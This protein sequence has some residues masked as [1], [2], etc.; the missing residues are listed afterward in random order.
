MKK[1]LLFTFLALFSHVV[2]AQKGISYQ[3][4]IIDP[5]PIEIPGKDI[6]GQPFVNGSVWVKFIINAG[7]VP[8]FQEVHQTSTDAYGLVNLIIGSVASS[9]FNSLIWDA[10]QKTLEVH[11]SF[12]QGAS[13]AKVSDQKLYYNPYSL[14]AETAGKLNGIL[15]ISGGGTGATSAVGARANLGLGNV[16]NTADAEKPVSTAG[17]AALNLK[18]DKVAGERL[19]NA[20]EIIKLANQSGINTGDQD[21]SSFATK[22][23]VQ[24]SISS[25]LLSLGVA[26]SQ[27]TAKG[28]TLDSNVL[29]LSP[30]NEINA[31]IVV[32]TDQTFGGAK[33][34]VD[35][36]FKR[37]MAA[38][39]VVDQSN[40]TSYNGAGGTYQWQSFT[41][42]LTGNLSSV[43]WKMGTPTYPYGTAAN[44][45]LQL[46]EGEG[47]DGILLATVTG[48]TPADGSNVFVSFPL[49]NVNVTAGST[50]TMYLTTPTVTIGWL[51]VNVS[52]SYSRGRGSNDPDWDYI[53][54]TNVKVFTIDPYLTANSTSTITAGSFVKAGGTSSEYLMADGTVSTLQGFVDL[55]NNQSING[56]KSFVSQVSLPSLLFENGNSAWS[57][58]G[59][60]TGISLIQGGCCSR[61]I[62]DDL[63]RVAIGANYSPAYQLD[64]EGN[65]RFTQDITVNDVIIGK[66]GGS[67]PENLAIGSTA[68]FFNSSGRKNVGIGNAAL[69]FNTSGA[70]NIAVGHYALLNNTTGSFNTAIG[71]ESMSLNNSGS[72][73]TAYGVNSLFANTSGDTNTAIG[74]NS[75][76]NNSTGYKNTAIG[77][78]SLTSNGTGD[79]LT[80][81]GYGADVSV[82]GLSNAIAIGFDAKV[83]TSNSIQLGNAEITTVNT[84]GALTANASV[85][86]DITESFTIDPSNAELYKGKII[87]CNPSNAI[88]ITFSAS[89]PTGFNCMVLQK[90]ADANKVT[91][92]GGTGVTIKNRNNFTATA[93]NYALLT[94]VHIGSNI[95]VTAGDMQ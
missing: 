9:S 90:S 60:G 17:L 51:D 74:G 12:N 79:K 15:G 3:A 57:F 91:I 10:N 36:A 92:V 33:T 20:S 81:I 7:S 55:T 43:E 94:V 39:A 46:Y 86:S 16:D 58:G 64:V 48:L 40:T 75:L 14:Y 50:Y 5:N 49:T 24:S 76:E 88:T 26:N 95:L 77:Y 31:G 44:V 6:T 4:V 68:L 66:G 63:G 28:A 2:N 38:N 61:L 73:N 65:A 45:T 82:D 93:G 85:S 71:K 25:N 19:I 35:G 52:N 29:K 80:S 72:S 53:F 22:E 1:I 67:Q 37:Q 23:L 42:G 89:L 87:V 34:F 59:N 54:K 18:V 78:G 27:S 84:S 69:K 83:S 13:Y 11:V 30:A 56:T 41:A 62:V 21:L 32:S 8:Q 70:E 47:L